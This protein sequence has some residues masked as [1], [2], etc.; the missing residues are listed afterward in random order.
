MGKC[1]GGAWIK[2]YSTSDIFLNISRGT[3]SITTM[4]KYFLKSW[5]V[6]VS[7]FFPSLSQKFPLFACKDFEIQTYIG[8]TYLF[9]SSG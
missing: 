3:F 1:L 7:L 4:Y 8:N 5:F 6:F 9:V 2:T